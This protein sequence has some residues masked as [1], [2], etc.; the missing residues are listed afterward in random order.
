MQYSPSKR[1]FFDPR[2]HGSNIPADA[3]EISS[4][5]HRTLLVAQ[6]KG[7]VIQP[8]SNGRP[9]AVDPPAPERASVFAAK[10]AEIRDKAEA[11]LSPLRSEYGPTEIASWDQQWQEAVAVQADPAA[12][13]P[14]IRAIANARGMAPEVLAQ[15]IIA[16]RA[17]WV[18]ISGHVV[19]QRLA[20]QDALEATAAIAD[21][22]EAVIAIQAINPV[23]TLPEADNA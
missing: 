1:G 21:D 8:D 5:E 4:E 14:L 16:N 6:G 20:Y 17:A 9:V 23:Y 7:K 11:I 10:Q 2:L 19:G 12:P 22:A 15:R 13:A 18:A 3:V